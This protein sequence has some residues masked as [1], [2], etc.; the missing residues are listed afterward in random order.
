LLNVF[1]YNNL[2]A[3]QDKQMNLSNSNNEADITIDNSISRKIKSRK[4]AS[5]HDSPEVEIGQHSEHEH[6]F[7]MASSSMNS[8]AQQSQVQQKHL[9]KIKQA[10]VVIKN[11]KN[12]SDSR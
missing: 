10:K 6:I 1:V 7:S 4:R 5:R 8:N 3:K 11:E 9:S 12:N 2:Q